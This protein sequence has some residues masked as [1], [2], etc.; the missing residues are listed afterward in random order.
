MGDKF[1]EKAP[2]QPPSVP[3]RCDVTGKVFSSSMIRKCRDNAVIRRYGVGGEVN[4]RVWA[5]RRCKHA[6]RFQF[7]GGLG[8][9]LDNSV[10]TGR[11]G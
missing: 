7:H 2:Y 10:Q 1:K 9:E 4:V 6:I 11:K 8:C 3:V 5:C